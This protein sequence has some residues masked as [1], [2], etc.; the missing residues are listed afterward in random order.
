MEDKKDNRT[1]EEAIKDAA[2]KAQ[3]AIHDELNKKEEKG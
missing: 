3:K 2:E 1:E